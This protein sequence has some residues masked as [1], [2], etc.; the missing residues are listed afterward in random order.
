MAYTL[1]ILVF[2]LGFLGIMSGFSYKTPIGKYLSYI[3]NHEVKY[4][5]NAQVL[6]RGIFYFLGVIA[7]SF[8]TLFVFT[9]NSVAMTIGI[10]G[11]FIVSL[12]FPVMLF[13]MRRTKSSF[14]DGLKFFLF[15]HSLVLICFIIF[16]AFAFQS[17]SEALERKYQFARD[18]FIFDYAMLNSEN[19]LEYR[20]LFEHYSTFSLLVSKYQMLWE[21]KGKGDFFLDAIS[22]EGEKSVAKARLTALNYLKRNVAPKLQ[23]EFIEFASS[24]PRFPKARIFPVETEPLYLA[25]NVTLR[26][27][28]LFYDGVTSL[29]IHIYYILA[30]LT[31]IWVILS[32]I[33]FIIFGFCVAFTGARVLERYNIRHGAQELKGRKTYMFVAILAVFYSIPSV[34]LTG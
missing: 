12:I 4:E 33:L 24:R 15:T 13:L 11:M 9:V 21:Y 27:P 2:I 29:K 26:F 23:D 22:E 31:R 7:F 6:S 17:R 5:R 18:T 3:F 30:Q 10:V 8:A 1:T 28:E 14:L 32:L 25:I 34:I 19:S 16:V 20:V